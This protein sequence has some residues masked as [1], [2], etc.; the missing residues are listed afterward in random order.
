LV[1]LDPRFTKEDLKEQKREQK[2]PLS[3]KLLRPVPDGE[4]ELVPFGDDP[5]KNFKIGED[6]PKL[7]KVQL[8]ACLRENAD[9]IAWSAADMP[10]IDASVACHQLTVD[11][12]VSVVAQ[13]RRKQ[14]LEKSEAVEK[15]VKD[16]VEANFISEAKYTT[17]LSNVLHVK[18]SNGK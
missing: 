17:W 8:I 7:V 5:S 12:S 9:L 11:P 14:F 6:I 1:E 4:F 2:D 10:G 18:K 15:S 13:R 16:L 3:A